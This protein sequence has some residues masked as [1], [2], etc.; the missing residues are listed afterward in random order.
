MYGICHN[1]YT[2]NYRHIFTKFDRP[3]DY[4]K[5]NGHIK[6]Q[7]LKIHTPAHYT[8][9]LLEHRPLTKNKWQKIPF[10]DDYFT[11]Q[12]EFKNYF[13]D[14]KNHTIHSPPVLDDLCVIDE[15]DNEYK[16]C[17]IIGINK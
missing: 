6:F 2:C 8:V 17:K 11:F 14:T 12:M 9:R 3:C 10:V 16:R 5:R 15:D 4:I 7:I 1:H 13:N